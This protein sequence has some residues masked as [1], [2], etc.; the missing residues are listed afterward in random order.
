MSKDRQSAAN[1]VEA[2]VS[3]RRAGE[4]ATRPGTLQ[5]H[6]LSLDNHVPNLPLKQTLARKD[7]RSID[8]FCCCLLDSMARAANDQERLKTELEVRVKSKTS[9]GRQN[10]GSSAVHARDRERERGA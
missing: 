10:T 8:P 5:F 1:V 7:A 4:Q 2:K 3:S 6:P 9:F